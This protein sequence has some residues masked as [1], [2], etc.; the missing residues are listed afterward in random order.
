M[1]RVRLIVEGPTEQAFATTVLGPH[2]LTRGV[3]S[4]VALVTTK[5]SAAGGKF[6]GGVTTYAK[7]KRDVLGHL[8]DT[9][10]DIVSTMLDDYGLPG[11]LSGR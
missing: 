2:L 6:G 4:E 9:G 3:W 11:G 10:L 5:H 1:K 8:R 7:L